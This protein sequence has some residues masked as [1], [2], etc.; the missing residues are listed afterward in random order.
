MGF[1]LF[2]MNRFRQEHCNTRCVIWFIIL[3]AL[4]AWKTYLHEILWSE[5]K[6][7][8][9][10][11]QCGIKI[12]PANENVKNFVTVISFAITVEASG[13]RHLDSHCPIL[14]KSI[15]AS[16][17]S[18]FL[19]IN[20]C[21][22]IHKSFTYMI[23]VPHMVVFPTSS[24]LWLSI[25]RPTRSNYTYAF[26]HVYHRNVWNVFIAIMEKLLDSSPVPHMLVIF[27]MWE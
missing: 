21:T 24:L 18:I 16:E 11:W 13:L 22:L 10:H 14:H 15:M 5:S 19:F 12:K 23:W 7:V 20:K 3:N 27:Y 17:F 9:Y 26:L 2:L 6:C 1:I 8:R 4:Q 25:Y